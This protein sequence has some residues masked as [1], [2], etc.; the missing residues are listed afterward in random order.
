MTGVGVGSI[1]LF[2]RFWALY[3]A[4][5]ATPQFIPPA[6]SHALSPTPPIYTLLESA[7]IPNTPD[8]TCR[9]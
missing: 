5:Q 6:G 2:G 4:F 8:R 3:F 7:L 9:P 1:V